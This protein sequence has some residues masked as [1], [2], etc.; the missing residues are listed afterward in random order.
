MFRTEI[1]PQ[2]SSQKITL[3]TPVFL[4]GSCFAQVIGAQLQRF[5]FHSIENPFGVVFNPLSLFNLLDYSIGRKRPK[6]SSYIS[7]QGIIYNYD[8]HSD[9]SALNQKELEQNIA[10][11]VLLAQNFLLKADWLIISLGTAFVYERTDT[12]E[13][14]SNCHKVPASRFIKRLITEKEV[15]S[16]FNK[17]YQKLKKLNPSIK[18][19]L[20]VS[21]VRHVKDT[22]EKNSL[23]KAILRISAENIK[24]QHQDVQYFP[25]FEILIDDLRD[26]RFYRADLL[27]PNDQAEYYIWSKFGEVFFDLSALDFISKWEKIKASLEHRPFHPD[28]PAHQAFIKKTLK[29]LKELEKFSVDISL[30]LELLKNQLK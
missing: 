29:Q 4:I 9:L 30:E 28:S 8:F 7:S 18:V 10:Q 23:S 27:H 24:N 26:Y 14:V 15:T 21:P 3:T 13:I 25:S 12:G 2:I 20:T 22:L 11:S 17:V 5:K 19:I 16:Q 1:T 6:P